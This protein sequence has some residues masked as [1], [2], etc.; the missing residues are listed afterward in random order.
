MGSKPSS[1]YDYPECKEKHDSFKDLNQYNFKYK[2]LLSPLVNYELSK[3]ENIYT[4]INLSFE[5]EGSVEYLDV[6]KNK[7][8]FENIEDNL[9]A[10]VRD[11]TTG[12]SRWKFPISKDNAFLTI[13]LIEYL[14]KDKYYLR[15]LNC[16]YIND[17][18]LSLR[19]S[20]ERNESIDLKF[21][22]LA[23]DIIDEF[24]YYRDEEN[25]IKMNNNLDLFIKAFDNYSSS[26]E[27]TKDK[28]KKEEILE[29]CRQ[30]IRKNNAEIK[31][32][33]INR[34][35]YNWQK[36]NG[37]YD[38]DDDHNPYDDDDYNNN[39]SDEEEKED[40]TFCNYNS[41]FEYDW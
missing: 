20:M 19:Q 18:F 1:P 2:F 33:K 10:F 17:Q 15:N 14:R 26:S 35:I 27:V 30:K 37:Y 22:D 29:K 21:I 4:N 24:I 3:I 32:I 25:L 34:D 28:I 6:I 23:I 39:Y 5:K 31:Q 8:E 11:I 16:E 13:K 36:E 38:F 40:E 41:D 7:Y 12:W 9:I